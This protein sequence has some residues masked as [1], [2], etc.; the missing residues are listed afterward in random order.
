MMASHPTPFTPL[1]LSAMHPQFNSFTPA[2][3]MTTPSAPQSSKQQ[4]RA[5]FVAK[6]ENSHSQVARRHERFHHWPK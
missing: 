2:V 6:R 3:F 1:G 5:I 4:P